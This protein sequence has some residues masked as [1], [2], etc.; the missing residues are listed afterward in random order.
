[1]KLLVQPGEGV[2]P[3]VKA[4]CAAK[5]CIEIVIFRF[6]QR[7]V[8]RALANAVSRGV[9]VHALI[10]ST[11]SAGA[12]NLRLLE[13]VCWPLESRQPV[14]PTILSAITAK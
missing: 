6:D 9:S 4:I 10:A 7:E 14:P 5:S 11:N 13:R 1:M 2:L 12:E 3:L 8:E